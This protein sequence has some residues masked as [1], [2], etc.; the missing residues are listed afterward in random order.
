MDQINLQQIISD[1][2]DC[3]TNG[4]KLKAILH[5]KYP[6]A[7]KAIINV[8]SIIANSGIAQDIENSKD[9]SEL[10]IDKWLKKLEDDYCMS[11]TIVE[12]CLQLWVDFFIQEERVPLSNKKTSL[13]LDN[14]EVI[15]KIEF[16]LSEENFF[17]NLQKYIKYCAH[18]IK[19]ISKCK[20]A[21]FHRLANQLHEYDLAIRSKRIDSDGI[22]I[23][24]K[25]DEH[26]WSDEPFQWENIHEEINA[27]K[28]I[29]NTKT[30]NINCLIEQLLL[31]AAQN[32]CTGATDALEE[33]YLNLYPYENYD[34]YDPYDDP[35]IPWFDIT[36]MSSDFN[37]FEDESELDLQ[38]KTTIDENI[39][40][41]FAQKALELLRDTR[42]YVFSDEA[43][44]INIYY[45]KNDEISNIAKYYKTLDEILGDVV[46]KKELSYIKPLADQGEPAMIELILD[47]YMKYLPSNYFGRL[48]EYGEAGDYNTQCKIAEFYD[49]QYKTD[50]RQIDFDNAVKW[51]EL[52]VNN[53]KKD[54]CDSSILEKYKS[55][56]EH[57]D[58]QKYANK[59]SELQDGISRCSWELVYMLGRI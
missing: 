43:S 3:V 36:N 16:G 48:M 33:T 22:S 42:D 49:S 7:S 41:A 44:N 29:A 4:A 13:E 34:E 57:V 53:K 17:V 39:E 45:Y 54:V 58:K 24:Y 31:L 46:Y 32:K 10:A 28:T 51:Y 25:I 52:A 55:F 30:N 20:G 6:N 11:G 38:N 21:A 8:I 12:N 5:D 40:K 18:A 23:T 56:L 9:T 59:I 37:A 15:N 1:F 19:N 26:T 47:L 27:I 50:H 35:K 14:E 2:P